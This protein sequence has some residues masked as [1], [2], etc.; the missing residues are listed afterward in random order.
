MQP[1]YG[2]RASTTP[3]NLDCLSSAGYVPSFASAVRLLVLVRALY[4][5]Y[6]GVLVDWNIPAIPRA[7]IANDDVI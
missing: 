4:A 7:R 6:S 5:T 2:I 1:D 3:Q